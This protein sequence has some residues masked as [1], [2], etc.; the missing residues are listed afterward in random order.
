MSKQIF[1]EMLKELKGLN[2]KLA[3][4]RGLIGTSLFEALPFLKGWNYDSDVL[5]STL[6]LVRGAGPIRLA[7]WVPPDNI[8]W[9]LG[10]RIVF[11]DPDSR[12]RVQL[13]NATFVT[14]P[15]ELSNS[16]TVNLGSI[17]FETGIFNA[18]ANPPAFSISARFTVPLPFHNLAFF[19]A[20]HPATALTE[21]SFIL[22]FTTARIFINDK[23]EWYR[24][25]RNLGRQET[26]GK[27]GVPLDG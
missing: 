18:A 23:K 25:L 17:E 4:Q 11:T 14:S 21:T 9:A 27:E 13:D 22:F 3:L 12:F 19:E 16:I 15:R 10:G 24:S 20:F 5:P 2:S 26:L 7:E 8:G 6:T 1:E